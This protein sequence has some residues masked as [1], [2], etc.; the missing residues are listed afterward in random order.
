[1]KKRSKGL[2]EETMDQLVVSQANDD[3]AWEPAVKVTRTKAASLSLPAALASRAAFFA[4]LH[5]HASLEDW[6][7]PVVSE[8][9]EIEEAV[10]AGCKKE[11]QKKA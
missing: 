9:L 11:L 3:T 2:S 10:F 6:I 5:R 8:R 4:R 7:K 1:M